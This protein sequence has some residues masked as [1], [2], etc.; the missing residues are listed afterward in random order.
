MEERTQPVQGKRIPDRRVKRRRVQ[1]MGQDCE[2]TDEGEKRMD[3]RNS[4]GWERTGHC[5]VFGQCK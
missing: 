2:T 1:E 4:I 3:G 5:R